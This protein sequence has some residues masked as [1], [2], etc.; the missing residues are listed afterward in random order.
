MNS[1]FQS[2][3]TALRDDFQGFFDAEQ[4]T[5]LILRITAACIA[6]G[7]VGY[8]R[9]RLGKSAGLR[10]HILV[11][12][13][14]ALFVAVAYLEGMNHSDVSRVLQGIITGI[15]FLGGGVILK[16]EKNQE[17]KGLTSAAA[18]WYVAALGIACGLGQLT[19]ALIGAIVG[20]VI[21]EL[22]AKIEPSDGD[23]A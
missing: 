7:I 16:L 3:A 15:G 11:T 12:V 20:V 8:Q 14:T 13:G 23:N 2:I 6:G 21:L 18:I 17:I 4:L 22:I 5:H 19:L 10:T 9:E 1:L